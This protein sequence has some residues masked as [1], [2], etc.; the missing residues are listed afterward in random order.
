MMPAP[1]DYTEILQVPAEEQPAFSRPPR[2]TATRKLIRVIED[3]QRDHE[4]PEAFADWF[5]NYL[6]GFGAAHAAGVFPISA[7]GAG[8]LC[9]WCGASWPVCGHHLVSDEVE[10]DADQL[11]AVL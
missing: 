4:S 8:P 2:V 9:S 3:A 10:A 5:A 7:D 6:E 11:E 1:Y